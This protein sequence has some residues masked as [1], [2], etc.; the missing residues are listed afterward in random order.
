MFISMKAINFSFIF[1]YFSYWSSNKPKE[2]YFKCEKETLNL[3]QLKHEKKLF[4]AKLLPEQKI[5]E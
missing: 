4:K 5:L 2:R 3:L 1:G